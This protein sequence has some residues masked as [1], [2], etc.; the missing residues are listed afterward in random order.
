MSRTFTRRPGGGLGD[1]PGD[2]ESRRRAV[3]ASDDGRSPL[4][5]LPGPAALVQRL[6]VS[7]GILNG[8]TVVGSKQA[9]PG[10]GERE[11]LGFQ[12]QSVLSD[13]RINFGVGA[14]PSV[15]WTIPAGTGIILDIKV[16]INSV[17]VWCAVAA[18]PYA[19]ME[20][21]EFFG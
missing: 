14:G 19:L 21:V 4:Q 3:G 20:G 7:A 17:F 6:R 1:L 16:P 10:H 9:I 11:L 8:Q 12:N 15:G 13:M 2:L 18:Q 5:P